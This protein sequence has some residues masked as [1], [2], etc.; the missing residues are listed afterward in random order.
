M[1]VRTAEEVR[2]QV[3]CYHCGDPV[4]RGGVE[5]EGRSFC[6]SGC[7][8]VYGILQSRDLCAYYAFDPS[9]GS[10]PSVVPEGRYAFLD[11]PE[12]SGRLLD[13]RSGSNASITL[14]I[15]AMHC[16]SCIWLLENLHRLDEGVQFARVDFLKKQ[17]MVRFDERRTTLRRV[18][19][20]LGKIGYEPEIGLD[21]VA[22]GRQAAGTR[23][24]LYLKIGV[25]GF[26]FSNIMLFSFPEYLSGGQIS[27]ELRRVFGLLNLLLALPVFFYSAS[28]YFRSSLASLRH[29]T[30]NIDVPIA[31][32]LTI[33][34]IRSAVEILVGSGAGYMDSLTGLVLFLLTGRVFQNKTYEGLNFERTYAAFFPLAVSVRR[35]GTEEMVPIGKIRVGDRMVIR[36]GE[37]VPADALLIDG[38]ARID[39]AFVTG[40]SA[41]AEVTSGQTVYAGGR[42]VAGAIELEVMKEVSQGYLAHLWTEFRRADDPR[43]VSLANAVGRW[44]TYGLLLFAAGVAAYWFVVNPALALNAVTAVLIIACPCALALACPFAYGTAM[45]VLGNNGLYLKASQVVEQMARVT[46]VVLDKTGTIAHAA[47]SGAAFQGPPLDDSERNAIAALAAQ[48]G[49]PVS[50]EILRF[51]GGGDGRE[52]T[53]FVEH[54]G[55]GIEADVAGRRLV[56]GS[57]PFVAG[58]AGGVPPSSATESDER[59]VYVA[60]DGEYRGY[61]TLRSRY[62]DGVVGVIERLRR[63][64]AVLML[65]GDTDAERAGLA[66]MFGG[67]QYLRFRQSPDDKLKAI[68]ELQAEGKI[69]AM[70]GDG[71]NDAGA[72]N[73]SDVGIAVAER[74]GAFSPASDAILDGGRLVELDRFLVFARGVRTIVLLAFLLS[75]VYNAVG[76]SFAVRGTLS[77]LLAA[78]LMPLSSVT[79]VAWSVLAT[80]SLARKKGLV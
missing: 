8:A 5:H 75:L 73:H 59:R 61:F 33:V 28:D 37:I 50:Q 29:R 58:R 1:S 21:A 35:Q 44:F 66:P 20:L 55:Q 22:A 51:L 23:R 64:F 67:D 13:F 34:F 52:A 14:R 30:L 48:S 26:C 3:R 69:V 43:L 16:S 57:S 72:L 32:G 80:R 49:H 36:H 6:C 4:G 54:T 10:T 53:R 42:Q 79:V 24:S 25:A 45:R 47:S 71:L 41:P 11:D 40:E 38:L 70:V 39:Y 2:S 17:V 18:V 46:A 31:L 9:P 65:S 74:P 19:E 62:R 78:V 60:F 77:P 63:R 15:P 27:E 12:L 7:E 56:L 68:R 76:L